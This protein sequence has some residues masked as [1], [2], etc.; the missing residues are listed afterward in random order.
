MLSETSYAFRLTV[1]ATEIND[2]T[3]A[4]PQR[5]RGTAVVFIYPYYESIH[6][7]I[8]FEFICKQ[9]AV[10]RTQQLHSF[11]LP[12]PS[13]VHLVSQARLA[14]GEKEGIYEASPKIRQR[15]GAVR[16][17]SRASRRGSSA[18]WRSV[19]QGHGGVVGRVIRISLFRIRV[20]VWFMGA[21]L[22]FVSALIHVE[23]RYEPAICAIQQHPATSKATH[24]C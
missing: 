23:S 19:E 1:I 24:T 20:N 2:K 7:F 21:H 12:F 6:Y 10:W 14:D 8:N 11:C 3:P 9:I 16:W 15:R 18:K 13:P 22:R 5:M 4:S 17:F